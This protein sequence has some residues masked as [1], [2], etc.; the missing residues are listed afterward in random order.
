MAFPSH[1][2]TK[3]TSTRLPLDVSRRF[4][5]RCGA[6]GMS[7][8]KVLLLAATAF[9][10][11]A[12]PALRSALTPAWR[13]LNAIPAVRERMHSMS[14]WAALTA[15]VLCPGRDC[16]VPASRAVG[17]TC[18]CK[19]PKACACESRQCG[20]EALE[21]FERRDAAEI[22]DPAARARF[23]ASRLARKRKALKR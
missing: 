15:A 5:Q 9:A 18:A 12:D 17:K 4:E 19:N 2:D 23:V 1:T 14:F 7:P 16:P 8:N 20:E 10:E 3:V 11:L 21:D 6:L 13:A 22:K